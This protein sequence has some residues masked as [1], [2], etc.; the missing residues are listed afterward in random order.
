[1]EKMTE[2]EING[3]GRIIVQKDLATIKFERHLNHPRE[4][5]WKA[6]TD[7][8]QLSK[9][10][11]CKVKVIGGAGGRIDLW[12]AKTHVFGKVRIWEPPS[13][14]EHEWNISPDDR[15]P[16]GER[17]IV[18]WELIE[19]N[20]GTLIKLSH[21]NFTKRTALGFTEGL[22]PATSDHIILDRLQ[23]FMNSESLNIGP[24]LI[25][26]IRERYKKLVSF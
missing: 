22:E 6:I 17:T 2:T 24:E 16:V 7:Q 10:Y 25:Q 4:R 11:L 3:M 21:S 14:F 23:A 8:D 1:M 26:S 18:R 9:W 19:E 12:F 5:V 20:T 13:V 15:L